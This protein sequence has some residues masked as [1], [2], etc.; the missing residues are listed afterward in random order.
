MDKS[1][2]VAI[3]VIRGYQWGQ[4]RPY[5][6][7]LA[8]SGFTGTKV[9]FVEDVSLEARE[10][11]ARYG[12]IVKDWVMR[13]QLGARQGPPGSRAASDYWTLFNTRFSPAID[14]LASHPEFRYVLY[15]DCRDVVFQTDPSAW[16]ERAFRKH[17]AK[18][19]GSSE[20]WQMMA[21]PI[22]LVWMIEAFGHA[23]YRDFHEHEVLCCGTLIGEASAILEMLIQMRTIMLGTRDL[24]MDQA[25]LNYLLRTSE[26]QHRVYIP[27]MS[28]GFVATSRAFLEGSGEHVSIPW[29]DESPVLD[30]ASGLVR[31]PQTLVPFSIVHQYDR[32]PLWTRIMQE[33]YR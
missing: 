1:K 22:N 18:I 28:E 25:V 26:F 16:L 20:C 7:S 4:I 33:K 17:G 23:G 3:S 12:F 10:N 31:A 5:V 11:L 19:Y 13:Q 2:D 21:Q 6:V 8:R 24:V 30:V 14:Y 32:N 29:T 9:I 27:K 15:T